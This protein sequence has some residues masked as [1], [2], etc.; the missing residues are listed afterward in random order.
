MQKTN[1]SLFFVDGEAAGAPGLKGS[2][3]GDCGHVVL[4]ELLACPKCGSRK[5]TTVAIGQHAE[6]EHS[7]E[8]FHSV[9]GFDEPYFIGQVK[10]AE[11]P[12]TFAPIAV[13]PGTALR[14]GMAL[15]FTLLPR[16][17]GRVGFTYTPVE[18]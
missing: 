12:R 17:D 2:C 9:D 8:V 18:A 3:C 11:G 10:T 4:L 15:R 14:V 13:A 1:P 7:A 6:L 16:A 5:L